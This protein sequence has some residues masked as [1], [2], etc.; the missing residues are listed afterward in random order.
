MNHEWHNDS[1]SDSH[2]LWLCEFICRGMCKN[3][4]QV[5]LQVDIYP[6]C[7]EQPSFKYY[8]MFTLLVKL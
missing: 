4:G 6:A 8:A 2:D 1:S 3:K 5:P 7:E